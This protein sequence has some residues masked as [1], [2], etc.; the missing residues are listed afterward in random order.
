[1]GEVKKKNVSKE[2]RK[3][4][5]VLI[6]SII[7]VLLLIIVLW[8]SGIIPK[9]I[10]RIS[11]TNYL[12]KSF[13][14][15]QYE[16]ENIEW[17]STMG[18][19]LIK[20]KDENNVITSFI[21]PSKYFPI[22]PGQGTFALEDSYRIEYGTGIEGINDFYN[23]SITDN[24]KDIR[25]LPDDY[26][27]DNAKEDN[28]FVI[29]N[30]VYNENLYTDFKNKYNKKE[31]AY[32]RVVKSTVE[33]DSIIIDI[34]Y[35]A[36]N[37]KIHLIKDNRRDKFSE[38]KDRI[39]TYNKYEKIGKLNYQNSKYWVAY[40]G[41]LPDTVNIENSISSNELFIITDINWI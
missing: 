38:K 24:Y 25:N 35:E 27:K 3:S 19:Y 33:G 13:P 4:K 31:N 5:K 6:I 7:V 2:N 37:N 30:R 17:S 26:S 11:A 16:Y 29:D 40:N 34:L 10:A 9:Q 18:G 28:C 8:I 1:M 15:K 12:K 14:K 41:E 23:H 39:I 20:F 36:N 22:T 21:M 32:I